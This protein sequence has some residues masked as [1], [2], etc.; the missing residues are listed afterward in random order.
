VTDGSTT[1]SVDA[2]LLALAYE[3][4]ET[5]NVNTSIPGTK[6]VAIFSTRE[7]LNDLGLTSSEEF[8]ILGEST[9]SEYKTSKTNFLVETNYNPM[10]DPDVD[11]VTSATPSANPNNWKYNDEDE[12][13][14][15]LINQGIGSH[16]FN[17]YGR[18]EGDS[19]R[20]VTEDDR[21]LY[22]TYEDYINSSYYQSTD[23]TN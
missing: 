18:L 8:A 4:C 9:S 5:L 23:D 3:Y 13:E 6:E 10:V 11:A 15:E 21:V 22:M 14:W 17:I 1:A 16:L 7:M 20:I 19:V 2:S 12:F